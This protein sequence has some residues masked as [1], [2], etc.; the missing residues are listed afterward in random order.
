MFEEKLFKIDQRKGCQHLE[1]TIVSSFEVTERWNKEDR[2]TGV[3]LAFVEENGN[4]YWNTWEYCAEDQDNYYTG[5]YFMKHELEAWK[6]YANRI[7]S[8]IEDYEYFHW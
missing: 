8:L 6:D 4:K 2:K 3:C 7:K 5:H 1:Y